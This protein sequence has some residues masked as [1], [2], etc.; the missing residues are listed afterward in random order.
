VTAQVSSSTP[1]ASAR[2]ALAMARAGFEYLAAADPAG[3]PSGELSECLCELERLAAIETAVRASLLAA[4]AAGQGPAADAAH[5]LGAWLMH[6]T[7]VSRGAAAGL[8]GWARRGVAHPLVA[9]AL[10]EGDVLTESVARNVCRWT[11]RL[12]EECR[13]AADEILVAAARAGADEEDLARLAAEMIARAQPD[14]DGEG[15]RSFGDR[16]V[17][18]ETTFDGAGVLR[19]ELTPECAAFLTAVLES[20]SA[21]AGAD[22]ERSRDQRY[23][24][25]LAEAARRLVAAGLLPERAGQPVKAWVHVSLADLLVLDADSKLQDEWI[26]AVRGRWAAARAGA[27]VGGGDGAAWL[28]GEAA[29][30]VCCDASLTPVVTGEAN[31]AALDGLVTLCVELARLDYRGHHA[32][33]PD[34]DG[35]GPDGSRPAGTGPGLGGAAGSR[36]GADTASGRARE[37]REALERAIIGKAV[38][39]VS[40]PGGLASFLRTRELGARL[41]GPSLPLDVGY[42]ADVPPSVRRAVLLRARGHCEWPGGCR[43]PGWACQV[44]HV[45]LKSQGGKTSVRECALLCFYHHE[46]VIHRWGWTLVVNGDGTT[47]AWNKDKTKIL[48]SHGPPPRPG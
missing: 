45:V 39:L 19:G 34:Q 28:E 20:L 24:D 35:T 4:F 13:Q 14:G 41:G 2:Q 27:S 43:Q 47:T 32:P 23:H 42:S 7:G 22:D 48:R 6:K 10:A 44:H 3:L 38:D 5:S 18:L 9:V 16:S 15:Q 46:V 8:V 12:P 37:A 21:P 30:A 11:D 25:A 31:A 40:G 17:R 26:A 29:R 1:P 36:A 33:G